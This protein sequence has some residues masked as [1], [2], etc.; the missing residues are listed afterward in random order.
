[1]LDE[2]IADHALVAIPQLYEDL[3]DDVRARRDQDR[4]ADLEQASAEAKR[5]I[6]CATHGAS[7]PAYVCRHLVTGKDLGFLTA[8]APDEEF[9]D[10]WCGDCERVRIAEGGEWNQRSEAYAD[11]ALLCRGEGEESPAEEEVVEVRPKQLIPGSMNEAR[12]LNVQ[13]LE[14][15]TTPQ[16]GDSI[17][18]NSPRIITDGGIPNI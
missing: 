18:K 5:A 9:P 3:G 10:A 12:V 15:N 16:N 17:S 13:A 11:V 8:E 14:V 6:Q 1:M 7:M 4:W 2:I